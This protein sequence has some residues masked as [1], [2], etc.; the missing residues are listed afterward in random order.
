NEEALT[1]LEQTQLLL[2]Q[3]QQNV[4]NSAD[5]AR[6]DSLNIA[7][8]NLRR[9]LYITE[10]DFDSHG[11]CCVPEVGIGVDTDLNPNI[12]AGVRL[13]YINRF[14]IGVHGAV[15]IPTDSTESWDGSVGIFFDG[16]ISG[17]ENTAWYGS[18]DRDFPA[19]QFKGMVGI[20]VY[21][22]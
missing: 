8:R 2:W 16:R 7:I 14:G 5:S 12:E 3:L 21:L 22:N 15:E 6:I 4:H 18:I 10:I 11:F 17:L 20:H 19:R 9:N 1:Q 13:Y